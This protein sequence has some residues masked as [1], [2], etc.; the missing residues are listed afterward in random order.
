[1]KKNTTPG[2]IYNWKE[3]RGCADVYR[4]V[5]SC[6][7]FQASDKKN[8]PNDIN[9]L[10]LPSLVN[11]SFACELYLKEIPQ[12][13]CHGH[14]LKTLYNSLDVDKKHYI[15][16]ITIQMLNN[17]PVKNKNYYETDFDNALNNIKDLFIKSRYHYELEPGKNGSLN[18]LDF[19]KAFMDSLK[20]YVDNFV[21]YA[22]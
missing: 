6:L 17:R 12:G 10:L 20:I 13:K 19:L 15:E 16:E 11:M 3:A 4:E 22:Y 9:K 14:N 2:I 1:M 18:N 5:G 8:N 21:K 7:Y